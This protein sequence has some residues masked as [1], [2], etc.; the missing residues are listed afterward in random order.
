MRIAKEGLREILLATLVLGALA[1]GAAWVW[2]PL[3]IPFVIVW[4]WVLSFFRDPRRVRSYKPG[5]ICSAADGTITEIARLETHELINGPAIRI[6]AFLSLFNVHVNR[7][8]CCGSVRTATY[9]KGEFLDARD[10]LS[11]ERNE[12]MTIVI[13][14]DFLPGPVIVRQVAGLVARRIICHAKPGDR[15]SIGE[16]FGLIKFGSRTEVI[17]P[18]TAQTEILV[19]P[20]DKVRG[21]LTILARQAVVA[22]G[23]SGKAS[24]RIAE[25]AAAGRVSS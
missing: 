9:R 6:G 14:P 1:G 17:I 7:A 11:G 19:K 12:A 3:G 20:G 2:W 8:P 25:Q 13:D 23:E 5:D 10:P 21:G 24:A 15:L 16:R 4:L 22:R 18:L